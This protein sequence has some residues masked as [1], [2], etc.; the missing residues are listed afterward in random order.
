MTR[1]FVGAML[2]LIAMVISASARDCYTSKEFQLKQ[3]QVLAGV[4]KDA[5]DAIIP[6]MRL[7][8][9]SGGK[10]VRQLRSD[11]DGA[12]S[13]GEV[14]TGKYRMRAERR[15]FCAPKIECKD[16]GCTVNPTL[17]VDPRSYTVVE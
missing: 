11:N 1:H 8:L 12:Y 2:V 3:S 15:G 6:G 4:L 16:K 17:Q 9:L 10:I 13:F 5:A 7:E 14:P